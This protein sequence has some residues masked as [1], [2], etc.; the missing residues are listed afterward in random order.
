MREAMYFFRNLLFVCVTSVVNTAIAS[1]APTVSQELS[2]D[3]VFAEI[4][5]YNPELGLLNDSATVKALKQQYYD[6][7][8]AANLE[9]V[10]ESGAKKILKQL[11]SEELSWIV[12]DIKNNPEKYQNVNDTKIALIFRTMESVKF[13]PYNVQK[14]ALLYYL[15]DLQDEA[16]G[17]LL[18]LQAGEGKTCVIAMLAAYKALC[19]LKVDVASSSIILANR[20][21]AEFQEFFNILGLKARTLPEDD[22][23]K[24]SLYNTAEIVYGTMGEFQGDYLRSTYMGMSIKGTRK[25]ECLIIDEVDLDLCEKL[26]HITKLVSNRP[27]MDETLPILAGMWLMWQEIDKQTDKQQYEKSQKL[28][29]KTYAMLD[30]DAQQVEFPG[31]DENGKE[32]TYIEQ[33]FNIPAHLKKHVRRQIPVWA[34][35]IIVALNLKK[36]RHYIVKSSLNV[37]KMAPIK[38]TSSDTAVYK[39]D[40]AKEKQHLVM[41]IDIHPLDSQYTGMTEL[42]MKWSDEVQQFLQ[43]MYKGAI[44]P[45]ALTSCYISIF[46]YL[47]LYKR[48]AVF[49]ATGTL[50]GYVTQKFFK[51]VYG[52]RC[53][54]VPRYRK[55]Q[56]QE[57]DPIIC[58]NEDQWI[59]TVVDEN[60][61]IANEKQRPVLIIASS[62]LE[63]N[64]LLTYCKSKYPT[65]KIRQYIRSDIKDQVARAQEEAVPGEL[66]FAT[67]LASRGTDIK[68]SSS[69]VN[70]LHVC[71]GFMPQNFRVEMQAKRRTARQGRPGSGQ[72]IFNLNSQVPQCFTSKVLVDFLRLDCMHK[73]EARL[74]ELQYEKIPQIKNHDELFVGVSQCMQ[75]IRATGTQQ[76]HMQ[77]LDEL[78]A[79]QHD[80]IR[81]FEDDIYRKSLYGLQKFVIDQYSARVKYEVEDS[82]EA[83][84]LAILRWLHDR[85]ELYIDE[86]GQALDLKTEV[87]SL[88]LSPDLG[89]NAEGVEDAVEMVDDDEI[90]HMQEQRKEKIKQ[91]ASKYSDLRQNPI[92]DNPNAR[93]LFNAIAQILK[94][95][96]IVLDEQGGKFIAKPVQIEYQEPLILGVID[97]INSEISYK[98]VLITPTAGYKSFFPVTGRSSLGKSINMDIFKSKFFILATD[99]LHSSLQSEIDDMATHPELELLTVDT[100]V[101]SDYKRQKQLNVMIDRAEYYTQVCDLYKKFVANFIKSIEYIYKQCWGT[102]SD[103]VQ[104]PIKFFV[105]FAY[106]CLWAKQNNITDAVG[107]EQKDPLTHIIDSKSFMKMP[108][109]YTRACILAQKQ[110]KLKSKAARKSASEKV[111]ALFKRAL[112]DVDEV[113]RPWMPLLLSLQLQAKNEL[114]KEGVMAVTPY[115]ALF[116]QINGLFSYLESLKK[117]I[118]INIDS[119]QALLSD[120]K[121]EGFVLVIHHGLKAQEFC[122]K[123]AGFTITQARQLEGMCLHRFIGIMTRPPKPNKWAF[124]GMML[125]GAGQVVVGCLL[126]ATP[127]GVP[128]II[129]GFSDVIKSIR[130]ASADAE[131]NWGFG[132]DG[133]ATSKLISFGLSFCAYYFG[134]LLSKGKEVSDAAKTTKELSQAVKVAKESMVTMQSVFTEGLLDCVVQNGIG[135]V[136]QTVVGDILD[137]E[138]KAIEEKIQKTIKE[139]LLG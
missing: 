18:Q 97:P 99:Q 124:V 86:G 90:T 5:G 1:I 28:I 31:F 42:K 75:K 138:T 15:Q 35:S 54:F 39:G 69:A 108:A 115:S 92:Q 87:L 85:G 102:K 132:W 68:I 33:L 23:E 10:L 62:I 91:L 80:V 7:D 67:K 130:H 53:A 100:E 119:L 83:L 135:L 25:C 37:T 79:L 52:L 70:G 27:G 56:Y 26:K 93:H 107:D 123:I 60:V 41:G 98:D 126:Y 21:R 81:K 48:G 133:Y 51:N 24:S 50:G 36:D 47:S 11:D 44:T 94:R 114:S 13:P 40:A 105:N 139:L 20:D 76:V 17:L 3:Q 73:E 106:L 84:Y 116:W 95:V 45:Q 122:G 64:R 29:E 22:L 59:K 16:K 32:T 14:I 101:I 137:E 71:I 82:C 61:K 63:A 43:L 19:G 120:P 127:A 134:E 74:M 46:K 110:Q 6:V 118:T 77:Q 55:D 121:T 78:W 131:I 65:Q 30:D 8:T 129:S 2:D 38:A 96:V 58:A 104:K 113:L 103:P 88:L 9:V 12:K 117:S 111:L 128:L 34:N 72:L 125:L 57:Y 4:S 112:L 89:F 66:I 109:L 136:L 49:G